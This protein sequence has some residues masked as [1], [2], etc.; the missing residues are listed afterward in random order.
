[1]KA[2]QVVGYGEVDQLQVVDI[3]NR[4]RKLEWC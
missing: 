3:P 1:M 2:V 4:H